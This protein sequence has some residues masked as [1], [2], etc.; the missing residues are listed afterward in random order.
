MLALM[1][2]HLVLVHHDVRVCNLARGVG[3]VMEVVGAS[4]LNVLRGFEGEVGERRGSMCKQNRASSPTI[5]NHSKVSYPLNVCVII[6]T[7]R[8]IR[9][10]SR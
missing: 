2:C 1:T 8:I 5:L 6:H 4:W 9:H 3:L 7:Y 10:E